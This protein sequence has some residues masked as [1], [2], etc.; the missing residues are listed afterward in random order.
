MAKKNGLPDNDDLKGRIGK[1]DAQMTKM[2]ATDRQVGQPYQPRLRDP[3][4]GKKLVKGKPVDAFHSSPPKPAIDPDKSMPP[5]RAKYHTRK[6][7]WIKLAPDTPG[8]RIAGNVGRVQ[9]PNGGRALEGVSG[10]TFRAGRPSPAA[11]G[12]TIPDRIGLGVRSGFESARRGLMTP[13]P[14]NKKKTKR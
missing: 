1:L 14:A 6:K 12:N 11:Y 5:D 7:P 9:D 4:S 2:N 3:I 10:E 8:N 13:N